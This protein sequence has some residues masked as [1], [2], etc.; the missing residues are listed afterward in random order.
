METS[1]GNLLTQ[2]LKQ[3][4]IKSGQSI[5]AKITKVKESSALSDMQAELKASILGGISLKKVEKED[6][7]KDLIISHGRSLYEKMAKEYHDSAQNYIDSGMI[8]NA[9]IFVCM[10]ALADLMLG[11]IKDG[12]AYLTKIAGNPENREEFKGVDIRDVYGSIRSYLIEI[13]VNR[14]L[15]EQLNNLRLGSI[16]IINQK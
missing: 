12:M 10:A 14:M 6:D 1:E 2:E 3:R 4:L 16:I 11:K 7:K 13:E 8:K 5:I 15:K 9:V